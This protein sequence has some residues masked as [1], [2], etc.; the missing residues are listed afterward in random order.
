MLG[1]VTAA[2]AGAR[3]FILAGAQGGHLIGLL[4]ERGITN[5]FLHEVRQELQ[6]GTSALV[7]LA[8]SYP[9]RRR[10]VVERLRMWSPRVVQSDLPP[11]VEQAIEE[12]LRSG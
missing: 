10:Q 5:R 4:T 3:P 12:A 6:P 8:R 11:E 1:L 7:L 9:E 2:I